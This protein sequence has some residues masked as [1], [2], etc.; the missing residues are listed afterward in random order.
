MRDGTGTSVKDIAKNLNFGAFLGQ[1]REQML[2]A[3]KKK[4]QEEIER[5]RREE[6]EEY[7]A[8]ERQKRE[9]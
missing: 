4:Q 6:E 8:R 1:S 3:K 5:R 9:D 2:E 7:E